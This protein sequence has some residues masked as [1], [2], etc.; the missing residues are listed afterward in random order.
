MKAITATYKG[1]TNTKG[2]RIIASDGDGNRLTASYDN[3]LSGEA[4]YRVAAEALRDKLGWNG[5]LCSGQTKPGV[6][7]FVF[8]EH[9]K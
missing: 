3:S 7:V 9:R 4:V 8:C 1:P 2:S 5:E 6:Y